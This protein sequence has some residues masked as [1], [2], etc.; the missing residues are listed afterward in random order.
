MLPPPGRLR[1]F[2]TEA[3][4][5][6]GRRVNS[7]LGAA[8][9][10]AAWE[11]GLGAAQRRR[12]ALS[13]PRAERTEG[14]GQ[15]CTGDCG[16]SHMTGLWR[17]DGGGDRSVEPSR[18][19]VTKGLEG[20]PGGGGL[21]SPPVGDTEWPDVSEQDRE[22][23]TAAGHLPTPITTRERL[24]CSSW[25]LPRHP[26]LFYPHMWPSPRR[27]LR[28]QSLCLHSG[29]LCPQQYPPCPALCLCYKKHQFCR[30]RPGLRSWLHPGAS[31][32]DP[33]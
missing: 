33:D 20:C 25:H 27:G 10:S 17:A 15:D 31:L 32:C 16:T 9:R 18:G 8:W 3:G 4:G 5:S 21:R 26:G 22:V 29:P 12:K 24:A 14:Q 30:D 2:K 1:G 11:V 19:L 28:G 23:L 6:S 13:Q 7:A